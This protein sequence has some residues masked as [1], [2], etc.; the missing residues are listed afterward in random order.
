MSNI[1]SEDNE[2]KNSLKILNEMMKYI[3]SV[4][5]TSQVTGYEGENLKDIKH[6]VSL[7]TSN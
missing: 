3:G 4:A 6:V 1:T 5:A 2:I 7:K